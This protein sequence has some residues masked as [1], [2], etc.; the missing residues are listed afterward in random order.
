MSTPAAKEFAAA[1]G[2]YGGGRKPNGA[3]ALGWV[4]TKIFEKV[5]R[6]AGKDVSRS[7]LVAQLRKIKGD[8]FGGLTVPLTFT[9]S[10]PPPASCMFVMQGSGGKW[11]APKGDKPTCF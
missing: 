8:R 6:A 9:A 11:A 2:K 7:S 5:V 1:W 4:G 3:A 10:G